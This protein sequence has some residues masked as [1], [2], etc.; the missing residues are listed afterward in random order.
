MSFSRPLGWRGYHHDDVDGFLDRLEAALRDPAGHVLTAQQVGEVNFRPAPPGRLGYKTEEVDAFV[1]RVRAH[2]GLPD[3]PPA[4]PPKQRRWP[5][6]LLSVL[7]AFG[8]AG[9]S[10]LFCGIA[11][12]DYLAYRAGTP[13]AA[14]VQYCADDNTGSEGLLNLVV[15][16][17]KRCAITWSVDGQS[18]SGSVDAY[19]YGFRQ[20]PQSMEV[21]V[22]GNTADTP[23]SAINDLVVAG[24]FLSLGVVVV[25]FLW[26]GRQLWRIVEFVFYN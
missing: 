17:I 25:F 4:R 15:P 20:R 3:P 8:V 18:Y 21:R 5:R 12:C 24:L 7:A 26:T 23:A 22:R 16:R 1:G 6:R 13:T 11:G 14:S 10:L 2:F 19:T 9:M